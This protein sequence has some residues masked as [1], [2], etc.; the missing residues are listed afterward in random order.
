[1]MHEKVAHNLLNINR[2]KSNTVVEEGDALCDRPTGKTHQQRPA[3][4]D[5]PPPA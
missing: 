2:I 4:A 3:L 5:V 1:M